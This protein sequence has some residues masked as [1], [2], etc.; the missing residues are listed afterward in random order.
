MRGRKR[1]FRY[2]QKTRKHTRKRKKVDSKFEF[3]GDGEGE[4]ADFRRFLIST[5]FSIYA[6]IPRLTRAMYDGTPHIGTRYRVRK[7]VVGYSV[8]HADN[9]GHDGNGICRH[10]REGRGRVR[11][12]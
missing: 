11:R 6:L 3:K 5:D 10:R 7:L 9:G 4:T 2:S 12:A 1:S 8:R